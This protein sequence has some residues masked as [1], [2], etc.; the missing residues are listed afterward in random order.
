MGLLKTTLKGTDSVFHYYQFFECNPKRDPAKNIENL[1][2]DQN[3]WFAPPSEPLHWEVPHRD[4]ATKVVMRAAT[5]FFSICNATVLRNK[6][7]K[8][9]LWLAPWVGEMNQIR[10]CDW[11]PEWQ[12]EA[13]LAARDYPPCPAKKFP[14]KPNNKSFIDQSFLIKMAGYWPR[15]SLQVYGPRLSLGP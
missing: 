14:R 11:L 1:K 7:N 5:L 6:L 2:W 8:F 4:Y 15:Y 3:P 10:R 13:I 12:V 9:I